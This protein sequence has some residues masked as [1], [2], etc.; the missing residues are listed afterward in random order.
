MKSISGEDLSRSTFRVLRK[1]RSANEQSL[2]LH[3]RTLIGSLLLRARLYSCR[4]L[5]DLVA[6]G[7]PAIRI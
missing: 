2:R 3:H 1:T 4:R 5:N 7:V 6:M